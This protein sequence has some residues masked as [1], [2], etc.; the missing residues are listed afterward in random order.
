MTPHQK[1]E[2]LAKRRAAHFKKF[3]ILQD[4]QRRIQRKHGDHGR[5]SKILDIAPY[6][7]FNIENFARQQG[8][9]LSQVFKGKLIS[10]RIAVVSEE[11][12]RRRS[13]SMMEKA[14]ECFAKKRD[15]H[16][17]LSDSDI[18]LWINDKL[19]PF[20]QAYTAGHELIHYQQIRDLIK[21][22][23]RSIEKSPLDFSQFLNFY[24]NFLGLATKSAENS[25]RQDNLDRSP[26]YGFEWLYKDFF[27]HNFV[28]R[29]ID[30]LAQGV[31]K[32]NNRL[33]EYGSFLAYAVDQFPQSQ[34]KALREVIPAL[35]NGKNI[36][37][38]KDIGL[39]IPYD[40][41]KSVL[42]TANEKQLKMY[43]RLIVNAI[44]S[45][46]PSQEAL[47]VIA[48]HQLYGVRF[49]RLNEQ[50]MLTIHPPLMPI[51]LGATYNQTQ[52]QQ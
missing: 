9:L 23:V 51:S 29:F 19:D 11:Y 44:Y 28:Y 12:L 49:S 16:G 10:D 33:N 5:I 42:P 35:E 20:S 4:Y 6:A 21:T 27:K 26:Y 47:R 24:G 38:A 18:F 45:A 43:R 37:F 39:E 13:V 34:A 15:R 7:K 36:R 48:S 30:D 17:L 40:E 32:W 41:V 14:G 31:D 8:I 3:P 46:N 50:D 22:E 52:Q 1:E 25:M 2:F